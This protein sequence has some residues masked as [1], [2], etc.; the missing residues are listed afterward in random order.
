[1]QGRRPLLPNNLTLTRQKSPPPPPPSSIGESIDPRQKKGWKKTAKPFR[2]CS[3][4]SQISKRL[5]RA[6]RAQ[7]CEKKSNQKVGSPS[8]DLKKKSVASIWAHRE[9]ERG[10]K[11]HARHRAPFV[12]PTVNAQERDRDVNQRWRDGGGGGGTFPKCRRYPR[13]AE[14]T[15]EE[16]GNGTPRPLLLMTHEQYYYTYIGR[17]L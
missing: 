1:M 4:L 6:R 10:K 13:V 8:S 5:D 14:T 12:P 3:N 17:C 16:V 9:R 11:V 15:R 7:Q 2:D